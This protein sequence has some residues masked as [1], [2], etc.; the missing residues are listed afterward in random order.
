MANWAFLFEANTA[1]R[2]QARAASPSRALPQAEI[3]RLIE[4]EARRQG[5]HPA[6][7]V[8]IARQESGLNPAA[9]GD[10]G[11]SRGLF[12][13]QRAAAIDAGIDPQRRGELEDNIRGGVTYFKQK[14][15]QSDGNVEQALSRYNRGTPTYQGRGDPNYIT[16][17]LRY[18]DGGA[19]REGLLQ[20]ASTPQRETRPAPASAPAAGVGVRSGRDW[21]AELGLAPRSA[22][23]PAAG[24]EATEEG[25]EGSGSAGAAPSAAAPGAGP[26]DWKTLLGFS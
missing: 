9:V 11:K 26:V 18:V 19:P 5:V 12:Q 7:A 23:A 3:R 10:N 14:L 20:Y 2:T 17:V 13:L 22:R 25:T 24:S 4:A 16:N 1:P 21:G 8:A 6:Y 15:Q